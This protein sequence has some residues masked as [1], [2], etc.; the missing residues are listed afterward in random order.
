M[1]QHHLVGWT[2]YFKERP[3]EWRQDQRTA[4]I[5]QSMGVKAKAEELFPNLNAIFEASRKDEAAQKRKLANNSFFAMATQDDDSGAF[6]WL[7]E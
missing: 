6:D 2:R 4:Y 7:K 5:C 1:P 3:P